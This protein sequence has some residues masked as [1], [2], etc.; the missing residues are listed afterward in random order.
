M[1]TR[2]SAE[3]GS[4][5][6]LRGGYLRARVTGDVE[7]VRLRGLNRA[8][9]EVVDSRESDQAVVVLPTV[10][11]VTF[12]VVPATGREF[13]PGTRLGLELEVV[14]G[15]EN[16]DSHARALDVARLD[17]GAFRSFELAECA[18][19]GASW[20]V[21]LGVPAPS[22]FEVADPVVVDTRLDEWGFDWVVPGR[23]ILRSA[24]AG[25]DVPVSGRA[26]ALVVDSSA[27][28]SHAFGVSRIV[29]ATRVVAG[30]MAEDSGRAPAWVGTTGLRSPVRVAQDDPA[31]VG[32]AFDPQRP[33]SWSLVGP[34]IDEAVAAGATNIIVVSDAIPADLAHV[35]TELST[36]V[37]VGLTLLRHSPQGDAAAVPLV[38][39]DVRAVPVGVVDERDAHEWD[40]SQTCALISGG[41]RG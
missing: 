23:Y 1:T 36:E 29:D 27:S 20:R 4:T 12:V 32:D 18:G 35:V 28:F 14:S 13:A 11:D 39:Q 15:A 2:I 10:G 24:R 19:G 33:A 16:V 3:R 8:G 7:G 37:A 40:W 34:C 21:G 6:T 26:W 17:V 38:P 22:L 31:A 41:R 9:V 30:L 25:R 5:A